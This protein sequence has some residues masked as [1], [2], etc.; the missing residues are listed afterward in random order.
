M[1][2]EQKTFIKNVMKCIE[3]T[4]TIIKSEHGNIFGG[5]VE[6]AWNSSYDFISSSNAYIFSLVKKD[7]KPFKVMCSDNDGA[8]IG[9]PY[10]GPI[11]GRQEIVIASDSNNNQESCSNIEKSY[12]HEDYQHG[13]EKAKTILA[14]SYKFKTV[15][16]E[17]FK[18]IN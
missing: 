3:N 17:V 1:V 6:T 11:F 8:I 10:Y 2:L 16:I 4:L 14:G 7:N 15:E 12:Q 9:N 13:T 18:M 5:F